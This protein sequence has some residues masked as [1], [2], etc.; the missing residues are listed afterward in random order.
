MSVLILVRHGQASLFADDYDRLSP[1]GE[2]QA[3]LLGEYWARQGIVIDQ[4]Y[5]GPRRRQQH[6]AELAGE[7]YHAAGLPRFQILPWKELDEYD[8]DG[9]AN[10]LAPRLAA[11]DQ[12]F[13]QL[14]KSY[15]QC[16][17]E[18]DRV[19]CFQ[20]VFE[21]L[22]HH[23]QT[24]AAPGVELETWQEF[25]Q[26]VGGVIRRIQEQ[27]GRGQR[28]VMLTSGGFIA[29]AAQHALGVSDQTMLELNWRI[30]N[31]S[32]TEFVFTPTR[33][34]LDTFNTIPHLTDAAY[35]TYR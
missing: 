30:R 4:V 28:I 6:T 32:L 27:S 20:R 23:W 31:C 15:L 7:S 22:L 3:R 19:R 11:Q 12:A 2:Q 33:F 1:V 8:L 17:N 29:C 16:E 5:A 25:R 10:R 18:T 21:S 14:L 35:C 13:A 9:L 34:T 26:R 24:L